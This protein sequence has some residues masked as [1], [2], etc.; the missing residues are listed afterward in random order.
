MHKDNSLFTPTPKATQSVSKERRQFR[1]VIGL[2]RRIPG[3]VDLYE[4]IVAYHHS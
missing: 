3:L 2:S 1:P 4:I